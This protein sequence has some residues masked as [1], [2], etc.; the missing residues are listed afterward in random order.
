MF[1]CFLI[2]FFSRSLW[3]TLSSFPLSP[4]RLRSGC[5]EKHTEGHNKKKKKKKEC[6]YIIFKAMRTVYAARD[7]IRTSRSCGTGKRDRRRRTGHMRRDAPS[8]SGHW[9]GPVPPFLRI[10]TGSTRRT[11]HAGTSVS[12][13]LVAVASAPAHHRRRRFRQKL[14]FLDRDFFR[15]GPADSWMNTGT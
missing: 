1:Y 14:L 11:C 5:S 12:S 10:H 3:S 7:T 2:S 8:A 13:A 6:K 15:D 4:A 9:P